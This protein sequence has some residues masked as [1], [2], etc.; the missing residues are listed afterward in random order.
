MSYISPKPLKEYPW[1]LRILFL[2]QKKKY[3]EPLV[4]SLQWGR[5]PKLL[6]LFFSFI[7]FFERRKSPLDPALRALVMLRVSEINKCSFCI[8]LNSFALDKK[9]TG[10]ISEKEASA[11]AFAEA[12]TDTSKQVEEEHITQL[13]LHFSDDE[14]AELAALIA[15]QN[16]SSK[17]NS[18]LG[19]EP[20][21][22]CKKNNL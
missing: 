19:I 22:F 6:K 15:F 9:K 11:M 17:F 7:R 12:V 8:D 13:K 5:M 14:I 4:P 3:G 1:T 10:E 18:A 16:M 20:H 21:G 2:Y